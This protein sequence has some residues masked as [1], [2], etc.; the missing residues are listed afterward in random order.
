MIKGIIKKIEIEKKTIWY[1][2]NKVEGYCGATIFFQKNNLWNLL[3]VHVGYEEE[4]G[5]IFSIGKIITKDIFDWMLKI[6][7]YQNR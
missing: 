7:I 5:N 3:G 4:D 2:S 1:Q 6:S